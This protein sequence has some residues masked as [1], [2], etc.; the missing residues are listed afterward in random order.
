MQPSVPNTKSAKKYWN[1]T[2]LRAN[3]LKW[4][5]VISRTQ[6]VRGSSLFEPALTLQ[7]I[8]RDTEDSN[9]LTRYYAVVT[10][11]APNYPGSLYDA[12]LQQYQN[13]QPI[14]LRIEPRLEARN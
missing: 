5:T 9:A 4:D 8:F 14:R 12:T 11:D 13:L 10:V 7:S 3:D 2:E 6:R 1:E